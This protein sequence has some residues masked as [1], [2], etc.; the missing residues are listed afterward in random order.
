MNRLGLAVLMVMGALV[1]G[2]CGSSGPAHA[3]APRARSSPSAS[4]STVTSHTAGWT[5]TT[6]GSTDAASGL[7]SAPGPGSLPQTTQEPSADTAAFKADMGSLWQRIRAGDVGPALPGFFPEAACAQ[8][9][10]IA[11]PQSDYQHR[12]V[13]EYSLDI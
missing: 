4:T 6:S 5:V 8:V 1:A 12:L 10:A 2:G 13:S 7:P 9:K 11:D 3:P